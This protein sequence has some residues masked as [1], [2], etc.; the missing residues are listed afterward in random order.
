MEKRQCQQFFADF[1]GIFPVFSA[2]S[3]TG[4]LPPSGARPAPTMR[5]QGLRIGMYDMRQRSAASG[6]EAIRGW[7]GAGTYWSLERFFLSYIWR[8]AFFLF[9]QAPKRK[10][11]GRIDGDEETLINARRCDATISRNVSPSLS[12]ARPYSPFR[13]AGHMQCPTLYR[14]CEPARGLR[15]GPCEET[16]DAKPGPARSAGPGLSSRSQLSRR[17]RS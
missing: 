16:T 7:R 2:I 12:A 10:N 3:E 11:G 5:G 15:V 1:L 8:G 17:E 13:Q 4:D 14:V 9:G 6:S